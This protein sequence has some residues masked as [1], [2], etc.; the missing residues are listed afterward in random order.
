MMEIK[1]YKS[2]WRALKLIFLCSIFVASGIWGILHK[3]PGWLAWLNIGFFG[4]GYPVG[5]YHFFDRRP[6]IIINHLGIFDRTACKNLINWEIIQDAY[7]ID[8]HH[9]KFICLV[10]DEEFK[11]SKTRSSLY[12]QTAQFNMA[13]GAQE[14][15]IYLGQ[16]R[17]NPRK[18]TELILL[19]RRAIKTDTKE[20]IQCKLTE[21]NSL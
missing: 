15:N 3:M 9:E 16:V 18:L 5:L 13:I 8:I 6:Q 10:V 12:K 17:V 2:P 21:W 7:L 11:P 20:S 4:L 1:L 19:M 14:L